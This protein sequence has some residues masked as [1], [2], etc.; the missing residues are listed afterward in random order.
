LYMFNQEGLGQVVD[1]SEGLEPDARLAGVGDLVET[2][3]G[4]PAIVDGAI[5]VRSDAHLWKL[6]K[7]Q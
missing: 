2:I 5:Y 7:T 6:A 4:T 1:L 3:L